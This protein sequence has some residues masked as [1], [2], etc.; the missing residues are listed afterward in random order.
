MTRLA[1]KDISQTAAARKT[2]LLMR[3]HNTPPI[4]GFAVNA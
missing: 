1:H 2:A 4:N 3:I